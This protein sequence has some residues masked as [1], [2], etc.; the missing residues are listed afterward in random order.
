MA[1]VEI[2]NPINVPEPKIVEYNPITGM[3]KFVMIWYHFFSFKQS[4]T[5]IHDPQK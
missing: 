3:H 2:E 4:S 5:V 1:D